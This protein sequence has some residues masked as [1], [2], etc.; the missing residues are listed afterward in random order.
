M[1]LFKYVF[2]TLNFFS[3]YSAQLHGKVKL[4][5][6]LFEMEAPQDCQPGY[7]DPDGK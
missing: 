1:F 6:T 2:L 3:I 7:K 5:R 4:S